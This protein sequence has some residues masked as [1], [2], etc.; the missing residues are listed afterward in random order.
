MKALILAG[1][2][3]TRVEKF[4]KSIKPLVDIAGKPIISIQLN[5][6]KDYD[7]YINCH[8][9]HEK[10]LSS[11]GKLLVE[12]K[13]MGN[14]TAIK[15]FA[16]QCT[17]DFIV[18]HCDIF[19]NIDISKLVETHKKNNNI[20]TM[21]V[22]NISK[23]K[24]FGLVTFDKDNI[25]KSFTRRRYV[26]CG[27]YVCNPQVKD[28]I[29]NNTF[30][31]IDRDLVYNLIKKDKLISYIHQGFFYDIGIKS[32]WDKHRKEEKKEYRLESKLK[33]KK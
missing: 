20:M 16:E 23:R 8:K 21:V 32:Y 1:G 27:V 5:Q 17:E 22:K 4:S 3:G 12:N 9:E 10:L 30:Q 14:A 31:D 24:T 13:R 6:L 26:N 18:I 7:V 29:L 15:S 11:Y 28:Y 2:K 33:E 19:S 25:I